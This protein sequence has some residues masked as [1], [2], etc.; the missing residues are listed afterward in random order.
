MVPTFFKSAVAGALLLGMTAA[1]MAGEYDNMCTYG[2]SQGK[3]VKTDCS[4]SATLQGKTYCFS[5]GDAMASF[6]Q[7]YK[8]NLSKA[9]DYY[10]SLEG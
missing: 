9:N 5:S 6:M 4:V 3:Q 1:A 10:K 8:A 7:D 2:L